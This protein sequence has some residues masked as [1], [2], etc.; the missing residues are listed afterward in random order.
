MIRESSKNRYI[1]AKFGRLTVID[2]F[3]KQEYGENKLWAK[4]VCECG[5][6]HEARIGDMKRNGVHGCGCKQLNRKRYGKTHGMSKTRF[7]N[8]WK[9]ATKRCNNEKDPNFKHYGG[10]GITI[11]EE[12]SNFEQFKEDMY[13]SYLKH[14]ELHGDKNTS[15]ERVDVDKGYSVN[16]CI[17]ATF[18]QQAN[19]RRPDIAFKKRTLQERRNNGRTVYYEFNGGMKTLDDISVETGIPKGTLYHRIKNLNLT[20]CEAVEMRR[21]QKNRS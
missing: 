8:I 11:S 9:G 21:H 14:C 4:C 18:K 6:T 7:Y 20:I 15:L 3:Q 2:L 5:N 12:W 10:R 16:N 1:G 13:E 19:N 17:W